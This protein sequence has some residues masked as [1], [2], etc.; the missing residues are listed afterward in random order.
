[1]ESGL[2]LKTRLL[3]IYESAQ[4]VAKIFEEIRPFVR[5]GV[6]TAALDGRINQ[7]I[8][9]A[10]AEPAFLGYKGF[11]ASA[12]ISINEEIVHGIPSGRRELKE[13]DIV[14]VDIGIRYRGFYGDMARVFTVGKVS[15]AAK[16]LIRVAKECLRRGIANALPGNR[17]GRVSHAIES[18]A[19][20]NGYSVV[21]DWVGHGIGETL[22][23]EPQVPNFGDRESGPTLE[24]GMVICIE[25]MVNVGTWE[26]RVL[27]DDWTVVTADG[28]LSVHVEDMVAIIPGGNLVLSRPDRD[29]SIRE[30][31]EKI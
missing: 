27:E 6:T 7:L 3:N 18:C 19:T 22:H 14:T 21:R 5:A 23:A 16:R 28:K 2:K 13:A 1:M 17:L 15:R 11:P 29:G 12:C 31:I 10:G 30:S 25:P 8:T 24:P 20:D 9:A 26:G 4:I